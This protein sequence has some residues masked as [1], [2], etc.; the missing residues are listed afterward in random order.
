MKSIEVGFRTSLI[1]LTVNVCYSAGMKE[2]VIGI[3]EVGRG[4]LAGPLVACALLIRDQKKFPFDRI[5]DSKLLSPEIREELTKILQECC[6][7]QF[8]VV[9]SLLIDRIGIQQANVLSVELA[10]QRLLREHNEYQ[11]NCDFIGAFPRYAVFQNTISFHVNGESKFPEI[12][13][14]SIAAKVFRDRHMEVLH[15]EHPE[16]DF[17]HNK[18]YGTRVHKK[19]LKRFGRSVVHRKSFL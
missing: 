9:S 7:M 5:R 15:T 8:G 13:A 17:F 12:A 6:D 19:A 14:A 10:L 2:I 1:L 11:L 3:D 4:A 16:Y 18:G